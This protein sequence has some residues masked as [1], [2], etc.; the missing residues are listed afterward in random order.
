MEIR[1]LGPLDVVGETA[2]VAVGGPRV[3]LLL[4]LL[5]ARGGELVSADRLVEE[6]WDADPPDRARHALATTVY[7]LRDALGGDGWRLETRP[8]GYQLKISPHE[9]DARRFEDLAGQGRQALTDGRPQDAAALLDE[10]LGLWRGPVLADL[11]AAAA[12]EPARAR[13]DAARI[14]AIE[15][16]V[17]ADLALGRHAAAADRL[18]ALVAQHPFRERL[19]GQLMLARYRAGRQAAALDAYRRARQILTEELGIEPGPKLS[20]LHEQILLHDSDLTQAVAGPVLRLDSNLPLQRTSFIGR[21]RELDELTGLLAARRLVTV[22]GP[23]GVGK[24][25]LAIA[26]AARAVADHPHGVWFVS[27]AEIDEPDLIASVTAATLGVS[28]ADRNTTD[29]LI[30]HLRARR[31]LVVFDNFEHLLADAQLVG[32]LLDAAPGLRI[33]VTSRAPLRLS[34]EQ[35]YPLTPLPVPDAAAILTAGDPTDVD[36]L[37]LFAD[38]AAALDPHFRLSA[39]N[40]ASVAAVAGRV[41]GLPLAVEL[42]AARLRLFSL[43]ELAGRLKDALPVLTDGAADRPD[44]QRTLRDAIA[45]SDELLDSAGQALF[46]RLG[47]FR[48]GVTL[49][50]AEAVASGAPVDNVSAGISRLL[51]ASLLRR[52]QDIDAVRYA[53]LETIRAYA[54]EELRR[55]G[56]DADIARRHA[57]HFAGLLERAE[58]GLSRAQ[59]AQW[60]QRLDADHANLL[61]ALRWATQSGDTDL[62]LTM[63]GRMWRY[64]QLRGHFAEGRRWLADL[65]ARTDD[66]PTAARVKALIGL[67]GLAYWEGDLDQAET[68][69][70]QAHTAAQDLDEWWLQFEALQGLTATIACHRG[71]PDEAAPLERQSEALV[72]QRPDD[73]YAMAFHMANAAV[74]RLFTGDLD[75]S[76]RYNE[77]VLAGCRAYGE[78]W[79][80]GQTLRTL[81]LTSLLQQRHEQAQEELL[82]SLE[83]A[84]EAGDVAGMAMDLD[85]LGQAAIALG[86]PERAVAL[87]GAASRL[88]RQ[89]GGGLTVQHYRW[90]T[91]H[92]RDAARRTLTPTEID[93]AWARGRS[94]SADGALGYANKTRT[95]RSTD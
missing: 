61:A 86:Q 8:P 14:S 37:A 45:W 11:P 65:L 12:L 83:I 32:R 24:T 16:R 69:Y 52:I 51:E 26:A 25:R 59:Q 21:R 82:G 4:A 1:I 79:Y 30:D 23:P 80:E 71:D 7:R 36:V 57:E 27:L 48:G 54:V 42:A 28:A 74:V 53:M 40:A 93:V 44:R 94:M 63:A 3:R 15:D 5:L 95:N 39:D 70:R 75:A 41:D 73:P 66:T 9:L 87:A 62:G 22:T 89:A 88:R 85:R 34:G 6:L 47:V 72:A 29:A 10:A 58:P 77:Q 35:E 50:A 46:R 19:W 68:A 90:E 92:P 78:R 55:C 2:D 84:A 18:E 76:R 43:D 17:D 56:E 31:M 33:L 49:D 67:A 64:W 81:A 91:E 60:L 13:L 20:R 38:R